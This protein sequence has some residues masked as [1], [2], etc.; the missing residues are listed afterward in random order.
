M[1]T[2]KKQLCDFIASNGSTIKSYGV[3]KLGIFGSFRHDKAESKSDIDFLVEFA[4][5]KK[6]YRNLFYLYEFL[7]L[8]TGRKIELVTLQGLSKY[9][10]P[11]ILKDVEYVAR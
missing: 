8:K 6:T 10:G 7:T 4:P 5:E 1:I 3:N 2:S 11:Y 9:I